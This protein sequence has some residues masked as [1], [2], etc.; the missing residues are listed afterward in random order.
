MGQE[1]VFEKSRTRQTAAAVIAVLACLVS[2]CG[3]GASNASAPVTGNTSPVSLAVPTDQLL[4]C[5]YT[6]NGQVPSYLPS[7]LAPH[8][9]AFSPD[10][11]ANAAVHQIKSKGGSGIVQS[12]VLPNGTKL[13]SGP[14]V[15]APVVGTVGG[16]QEVQLYDPVLWTDSGG[17]DWLAFFLACGG[18]NLYWAGLDDLKKTSPST[19]GAL[20]SQLAQLRSAPPYTKTARASLLPIVVDPANRLSWKDRVIPFD[21]GRG[22]LISAL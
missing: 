2:A 7:G 12:F 10:P 3:S 8:F 13:R 14:S 11:S 4:G 20:S 18:G 9:A 6:V 5:T 15:S 16:V 21:V 1:T 19:A 22:E 17:N